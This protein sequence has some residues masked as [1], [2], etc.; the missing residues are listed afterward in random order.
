MVVITKAA[1]VILLYEKR[2]TQRLKQSLYWQTQYQFDNNDILE[3]ELSIH[4]DDWGVQ[5]AYH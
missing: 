5:L 4:V 1:D 3:C 2:Q